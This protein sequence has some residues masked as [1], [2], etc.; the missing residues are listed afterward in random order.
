M[1]RYRVEITAPA[2]EHIRGISDWW[3]KNRQDRPE[4]FKQELHQA[5]E[6][7]KAFPWAGPVHASP[8][9]RD[10]RH[11]LLRRTQYHVYY[12]VDEIARTVSIVA[13]W[14]TARSARPPI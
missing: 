7:L 5:V 1:K 11:T 9:H 3:A 10:V 13:V 6:L 12:L 4:L 14:H 8:V 2:R